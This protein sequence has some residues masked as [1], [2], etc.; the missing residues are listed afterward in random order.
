MLAA[1]SSAPMSIVAG[2]RVLFLKRLGERT[3]MIGGAA[4]KVMQETCLVAVPAEL[5]EEDEGVMR[6]KDVKF[7]VMRLRIGDLRP[8]SQE[9]RTSLT[10]QISPGTTPIVLPPVEAPALLAAYES[11]ESDALET[12][13][14]TVAGQAATSPLS[15]T[16]SFNLVA[17]ATTAG[18]VKGDVEQLGTLMQMMTQVVASQA[19]MQA[20]IVALEAGRGAAPGRSGQG[21]ATAQ[22][23]DRHAAAQAAAQLLDSSGL[24]GGPSAATASA[25]APVRSVGASGHPGVQQQPRLAQVSAV[26]EAPL[27]E[28]PVF[29]SLESDSEGSEGMSEGQE[30]LGAPALIAAFHQKRR[31]KKQCGL[32]GP[33][34][35]VNDP[36]M[37]MQW[38]MVKTLKAMRRSSRRRDDSS[39]SEDGHMRGLKH[40]IQGLHRMRRRFRRAPLRVLIRYRK[41]VMRRLGVEILANGQSSAP[42]QHTDYSLKLKPVFGRMAGLWRMHFTLSRLLSLAES[43]QPELLAGTLVQAL[44][45]L[46]QVAI[47]GGSWSN[48]ALLLPWEDPL[49]KELWAGSDG[50]MEAAVKYTRGVKDL[51]LKVALR[52]GV[53]DAVP[54]LDDAAAE[55]GK[56]QGRGA[57]RAAAV[58]AKKNAKK[59]DV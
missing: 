53:P 37:A 1:S 52:E 55:P 50:E 7:A 48:A 49:S 13:E 32:T 12:A 3:V 16:G 25:P 18:G 43:Q 11:M 17:S 30:D 45:A 6:A 27:P 5:S 44:K 24:W 28:G 54:E 35:N 14:E 51:S 8:D 15:S 42:W 40:G 47:D 10:P 4:L 36:V 31:Q 58:A 19:D 41:R 59:E 22:V 57:R 9:T 21:G 46:H 2:T 33:S 26:P 38:E 20:K 39:D 34:F 29:H 23:A 56:G